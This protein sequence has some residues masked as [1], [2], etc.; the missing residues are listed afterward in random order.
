MLLHTFIPKKTAR[1]MHFYTHKGLFLG[2]FIFFCSGTRPA[3]QAY[4][5]ERKPFFSRAQTFLIT[6]VSPFY[7]ERKL[8]KRENGRMK[9]TQHGLRPNASL[10]LLGDLL[11]AVQSAY[12]I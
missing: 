12:F 4:A 9:R 6:S 8:R 3:G 5:R 1:I 7:H 2:S 10:P 11:F